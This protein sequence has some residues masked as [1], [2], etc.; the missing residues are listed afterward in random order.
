MG[1][2]LAV[3]PVNFQKEDEIGHERNQAGKAK[4]NY[5]RVLSFIGGSAGDWP[6]HYYFHLAGV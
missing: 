1:S 5:G 4:R 3:G 6:L 2:G